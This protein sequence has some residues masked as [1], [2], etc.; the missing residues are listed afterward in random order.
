VRVVA[1]RG[2]ASNVLL[3]EVGDRPWLIRVKGIADI[4]RPRVSSGVLRWW[5]GLV[6]SLLFLVLCLG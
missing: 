4:F 3:V 5:V 2:A 1:G 6:C